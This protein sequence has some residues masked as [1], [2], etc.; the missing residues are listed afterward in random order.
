[1]LEK[2]RKVAV[3]IVCGRRKRGIDHAQCKEEK[4]IQA[5]S[6]RTP[7]ARVLSKGS[8]DGVSRKIFDAPKKKRAQRKPRSRR[9]R[10][11]SVVTEK[12]FDQLKQH[13]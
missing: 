9:K 6:F 4:G 5:E 7:V 13:I 12:V 2:R 10:K 1:M 3:C 8:H 11:G